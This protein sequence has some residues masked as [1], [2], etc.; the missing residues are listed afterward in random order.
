MTQ[1]EINEGN[2]L[3]ALTDGWKFNKRGT[4]TSKDKGNFNWK[5]DWLKYHSSW[6]WQ[7]PVWAKLNAHEQHKYHIT[8]REQGDYATAVRTNNPEAGFKIIISILK[9][10]QS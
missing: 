3:I 6:G 9:R 2:K 4:F 5:I 10:I 7:I 8:L 1:S